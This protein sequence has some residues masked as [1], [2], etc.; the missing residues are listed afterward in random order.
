M[1]PKGIA[2]ENVLLLVTNLT[3]H[4]KSYQ[5]NANFKNLRRENKRCLNL[6][7]PMLWCTLPFYFQFVNIW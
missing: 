2:P 1:F 3:Q 6:I 4:A 5:G 7:D